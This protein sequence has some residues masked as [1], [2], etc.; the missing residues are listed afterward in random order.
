MTSGSRAGLSL[1]S[2]QQTRPSSMVAIRPWVFT[3]G[4]PPTLVLHDARWFS[5]LLQLLLW[6]VTQHVAHPRHLTDFASLSHSPPL[7]LLHI[8]TSG[9]YQSALVEDPY[10]QWGRP[11]V[12]ISTARCALHLLRAFLPC[13]H[14]LRAFLSRFASVFRSRAHTH[15][16]SVASDSPG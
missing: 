16:T 13:L 14:L 7:Y 15:C 11:H 5:S 2:L 10:G 1:L 6:C 8:Y 12:L 9:T 4:F 3:L